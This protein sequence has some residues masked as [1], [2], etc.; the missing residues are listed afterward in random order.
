M[1]NGS[2]ET[3]TGSSAPWSVQQPYLQQAFQG[4]QDLYNQGPQSYYPGQ[5]YTDMNPTTAQGLQQQT[6]IANSANPVIDNAANYTSK[7]LAGNTGNPW[8]S[9]LQSGVSGMQDTASGANLNGNPYLDEMYKSATG[10][11]KQDFTDTVVP[12]ISSQ[13]GQ[14]GMTG[15]TADELALGKAGGELTTQLGNAA[16]NI[17]GGNYQQER[18]RQVAAQQGLA[19]TGSNLFNTNATQ[20]TAAAGMA[21]TI[22][23]AQFGDANK[24]KEAGAAYNTQDEK[25]LED[26]INRYNYNQNASGDALTKYLGMIGGN[27]GTEN[28]SATSKQ[29]SPLNTF[30]GGLST[31]AGVGKTMSGGK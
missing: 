8:Q 20:Q 2:T 7:T 15:S 14:S 17:Y 24:L 22:R 1:G 9:M 23:E 19:N 18:D 3:T 12:A 10:K 11:M 29:G 16:T 25:A 28:T 27:Y 31:A 6:S 4:A 26:S 30:L 5:T 13:F 21:P